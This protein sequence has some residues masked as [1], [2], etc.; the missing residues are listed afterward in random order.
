[1]QILSPSEFPLQECTVWRS[2]LC[3]VSLKSWLGS[4]LTREFPLPTPHVVLGKASHWTH[5]LCCQKE[6]PSGGSRN[7][8]VQGQ[9]GLARL[10]WSSLNLAPWLTSLG[11]QSVEGRGPAGVC[12]SLIALR[13]HEI[14]QSL[15]WT[16][17]WRTQAGE[18]REQLAAGEEKT[19]VIW[20]VSTV[21]KPECA[22]LARHTDFWLRCTLS[23]RIA[24]VKMLAV[25][26]RYLL[27]L[28]SSFDCN[29]LGSWQTVWFCSEYI[30]QKP[31]PFL[32]F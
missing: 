5:L 7:D 32:S 28:L 29:S 23:E 15:L 9:P 4:S 27:L 19:T 17:G 20:R 18:L 10:A 6:E 1:M 14:L 3:T 8:K 31:K 21:V 2:W 22:H 30:G 16:L 26:R 24:L 25:S 11:A 12:T 13:L